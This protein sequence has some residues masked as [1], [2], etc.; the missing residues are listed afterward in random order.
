MT[1]KHWKMLIVAVGLWALAMAHLLTPASGVRATLNCDPPCT[2]VCP[3]ATQSPTETPIPP[4]PTN[5]PAPSTPTPE[6]GGRLTIAHFTD[7]HVGQSY[8]CG[9]R[10]CNWV[11]PDLNASG[12]DVAIDTGDCTE[13]GFTS[14]WRDYQACTDGL[15]VPWKAV[16]GNH[17]NTW[18]STMNEPEW[19]WDVNG[20]RLIGLNTRAPID[21]GWLD[22]ALAA[23]MPTLL[24]GHYQ[25]E[26]GHYSGELWARLDRDNVLAFVYGH[27]HYNDLRWYGDT[28]LLITSRACLGSWS[29]I[30]VDGRDITVER[31]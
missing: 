8:I 7:A 17:D 2:C 11:V 24:F 6:A 12:A 19:I 20:Y 30:T 22:D 16:P 5:T 4:E 15:T 26:H 21:W 25:P 1:N 14:E 29:L 18:P 28:M 10:L 3:T 31:H 27:L 9:Y 13:L 23:G